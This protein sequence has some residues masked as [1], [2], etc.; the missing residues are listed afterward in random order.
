MATKEE[1]EEALDSMQSIYCD[2]DNSISAGAKFNNGVHLLYELVT[3][4]FEEKTETNYEHFED[5][6]K[7]TQFNFAVRDGEVVPCKDCICDECIFEDSDIT[8]DITR[9]K[10]L[11]QKH[12]EKVELTQF[13]YDLLRTNNMSHDRKLSSFATYKGLKEIGYFKDIN[14]NLTIDE[15]LSKCEVVG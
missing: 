2:L 11:L 6:I 13:E 1:Y 3:E 4:H 8:C 12:V 7:D 5:E 15:V 9:M 14:F 10:W